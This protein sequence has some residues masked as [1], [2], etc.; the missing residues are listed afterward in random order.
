[1]ALEQIAIRNNADLIVLGHGSLTDARRFHKHFPVRH[2]YVSED[3]AAFKALP[4]H[5][6]SLV[7]FVGPSA[8]LSA[9]PSAMKSLM[10][11]GTIAAKIEQPLPGKGDFAQMGGQMY[12]GPGNEC[13]FMHVERTPGSQLTEAQILDVTG[14]V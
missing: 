13:H 12:I 2:L 11:P 14:W 5:R 8:I 1:L 6:G 7:D 10:R 3:F 9:V 4:L